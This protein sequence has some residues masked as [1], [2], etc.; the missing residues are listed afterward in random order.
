MDI[1]PRRF[2]YGVAS[3]QVT[4]YK[5]QVTS[6]R[7]HVGLIVYGSLFTFNCSHYRKLVQF[8]AA[9]IPVGH[10]A[11]EKGVVVTAVI[12]FFE[13]GQFVHDHIVDAG[14][15]GL[16]QAQI[17]I[18]G[19]FAGA[20]APTAFHLADL[21][22]GKGDAEWGGV[23]VERSQSFGK[24]DLGLPTVPVFEQL[25]FAFAIVLVADVQV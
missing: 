3:E 17:E 8:V 25:L 11:V 9:L 19:A 22:W 14:G 13:V 5:L 16:D 20:A 24:D 6:Y 7:R 21:H 1:S 23:G 4:D 18:D 10:E 12:V 2:R 15:A